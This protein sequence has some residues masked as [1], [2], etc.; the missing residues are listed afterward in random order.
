MESV[1]FLTPIVSRACF[2]EDLDPQSKGEFIKTLCKCS[3][4]DED[5]TQLLFEH[6]ISDLVDTE[7]LESCEFHEGVYFL[8]GA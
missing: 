1:Q 8:P 7:L 2:L 3:E 4:L 5:K 6:V